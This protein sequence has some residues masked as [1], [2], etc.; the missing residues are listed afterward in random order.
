MSASFKKFVDSYETLHYLTF[1][2]RKEY[3][4]A[5]AGKRCAYNG[6]GTH[7][8]QVCFDEISRVEK[9]LRKIT[10]DIDIFLSKQDGIKAYLEQ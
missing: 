8:N 5:K 4:Y 1:N 10:K 3:R 6:G 2:H 9:Q 7:I